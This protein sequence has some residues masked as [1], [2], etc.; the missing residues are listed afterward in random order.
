MANERIELEFDEQTVDQEQE[1]DLEAL[2]LLGDNPVGEATPHPDEDDDSEP[3]NSANEPE[4][5]SDSGDDSGDDADA[6]EESQE[7]SESDASEEE[8]SEEEGDAEGDDA[9]GEPEQDEVEEHSIPKARLDREIQKRRE[10]EEQMAEI[11]HQMKLIQKGQG[12]EAP[13]Q[14][15]A[16]KEPEFDTNAAEKQYMDALMDGDTDKAFEIRQQ[17]N[18]EQERRL[19]EELTQSTTKTLEQD[20]QQ[21]EFMDYANKLQSE[22]P[23]FDPESSDFNEDALKYALELRD[24]IIATGKAPKDALGE[25]VELAKLKFSI[26][27]EPAKPADKP[28]PKATRPKQSL[29]KKIE[30]ANK[31]PGK[32]QGVSGGSDDDGLPNVA[33]MSSDEWEALP[34][35]VQNKL[36][37][38]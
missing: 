12:S 23:Q 5:E 32:M 16:P 38:L 4:D 30:A 8:E 25:A 37:G 36:L 11:Q 19:R 31:Q 21:Q 29:D 17:I 3:V 15:E 24:G 18:Q 34:E 9:S 35:S 28:K 13:K 2:G 33:E 20:K 27:G 10:L 6:E 22:N 1:P 7:D 14:D 26:T